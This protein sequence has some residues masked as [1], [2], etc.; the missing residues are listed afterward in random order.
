M[1][2]AKITQQ[3]NMDQPAGR[4]PLAATQ[5]PKAVAPATPS[6]SVTPASQDFGRANAIHRRL[7]LRLT[8]TASKSSA[9]K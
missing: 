7:T 5:S 3:D 2:T 8:A 9:T 4:T 6:T 1:P